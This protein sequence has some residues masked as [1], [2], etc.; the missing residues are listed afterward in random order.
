[1]LRLLLAVLALAGVPGTLR[2]QAVSVPVSAVIPSAGAIRTATVSNLRTSSDR[3]EIHASITITGAHRPIVD[4]W[5]LR[6][7]PSLPLRRSPRSPVELTR[8]ST[9]GI[10]PLHILAPLAEPDTRFVVVYVNCPNN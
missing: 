3:A 7:T 1:M 10:Y 6:A 2:A 8:S 9:P 4:A 5:V